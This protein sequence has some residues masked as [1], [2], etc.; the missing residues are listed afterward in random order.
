MRRLIALLWLA[1]ILGG[2]AGAPDKA[3]FRLG[4]DASA[5]TKRLMWPPEKAGEVPRYFY[6]GEITGE[7]NFVRPE[8]ETG[9]AKNIV[10]RFFNMVI[11]ETPPLLLDRPQSGAVDESGRILVTDMG[12]GGVFVFDEKAGKL[13]VWVKAVGAMGF[14]AP[15]GIAVGP[16]GHVFVADPELALIA[17][18]DREGNTMAPIGKGQLQRPT[19]LAY[20][21]ETKRLFVSDTQAH[22]IKVFDLEGKLLLTLGEH[23]EGPGQ[24]NYPTYI[25]VSHEKLYVSDTLN[26][27]VQVI[28]TPTGRYL[29]TVGNRGLFVGNLVRPKG[30]AADSEHNIY[31]IES[32]FDYMLVYNR[33]GKFLLP[34]GGVGDGPGNFHLPAGVWVDARN[35]VFVADMLNGRIAVFQFLGGEEDNEDR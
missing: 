24:F 4:L 11:G 20:E 23:G 3:V 5:E 17:H 13:S 21:P 30:V 19:G 22:Q 14:I 26:A 27:R 6:A 28:S 34:I 18:L 29:F 35:R 12:H 16:E 33:R 32:Y 10:A 2:C 31:V 9:A 7:N 15:V 25:A 8:S 1:L